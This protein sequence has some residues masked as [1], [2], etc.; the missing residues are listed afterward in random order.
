MARKSGFLFVSLYMK[1]CGVS[2][3]RYYAGSYSKGEQL[4][5]PI[6]L[7]RSGIPIIIPSHVRKVM[8][9]CDDRA[10]RWVR[11]Y[12]SWFGVARLILLVKRVSSSTFE[13]ITTP[14]R[15]IDS[16]EEVLTMLRK[17]GMKRIS[18]YLPSVHL[19]PLNQGF[20]WK[21][22]WKSTPLGE[23]YMLRFLQKE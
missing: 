22:T 10:D 3:Q 9:R 7:T 5:V 15:D 8:R 23:S 1:Q 21:P 17:H 4:S 16:V 6:A 12:L 2:L 20:K 11:I 14:T 13:S 18:T 19:I